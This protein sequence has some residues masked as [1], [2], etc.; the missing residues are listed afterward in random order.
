MEVLDDGI[1]A[2]ISLDGSFSHY[3]ICEYLLQSIFLKITGYQE[4]KLKCIM[5]ELATYDYSLRYKYLN[6]S[7]SIGECSNM[8]DKNKVLAALIGTLE[9]SG[10]DFYFPDKVSNQAQIRNIVDALQNRF[11]KSIFSKWLARDFSRFKEFSNSIE[12]HE[13]GY[14]SS[15]SCFGSDSI[16]NDAYEKV[17]IHRNRCAHNLLSYQ[18]NVPTL[19]ELANDTKG[20]DN[21]FSRILV[22]FLID[23]IYVQVFN[24]FYR[25]VLHR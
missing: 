11:E 15:K 17:F 24:H 5:W 14:F 12:A 21:Y 9:K 8:E 13:G 19:Q 16:L 4:Q 6:G 7:I 1:Q 20:I 22:L 18:S 23:N 3:P 2:S 25:H 10:H